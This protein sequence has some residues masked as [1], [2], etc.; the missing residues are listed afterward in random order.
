MHFKD[1][2]CTIERTTDT[3]LKWSLIQTKVAVYTNIPCAFWGKNSKWNFGDTPHAYQTSE[4]VYELNLDSQYTNVQQNDIVTV[5]GKK[6]LVYSS[7]MKH[8]RINGQLHNI[9]LELKETNVN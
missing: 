7:P 4:L 6:Y 3:M 9:H 8:H 5:E 1:Y 2:I